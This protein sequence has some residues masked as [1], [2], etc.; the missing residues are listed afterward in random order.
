MD[1]CLILNYIKSDMS[2]LVV[3]VFDFSTIWRSALLTSFLS[4]VYVDNLIYQYKLINVS[5]V[6]GLLW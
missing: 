3:N 1:I 2:A 4:C 6:D 5:F